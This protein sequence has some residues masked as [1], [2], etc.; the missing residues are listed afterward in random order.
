MTIDPA[1][2]DKEEHARVAAL[3]REHRSPL[4][5][6]DPSEPY[7]YGTASRKQ[8]RKKRRMA[9]VR[10]VGTLGLGPYAAAQ[11]VQKALAAREEARSHRLDGLTRMMIEGVWQIPPERRPKGWEKMGGKEPKA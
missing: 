5:T 3:I 7:L 10:I 11:Q 1:R 6:L 4:K 9:T 8:E 2:M